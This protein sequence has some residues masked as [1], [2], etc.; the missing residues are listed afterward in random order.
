MVRAEG[1]HKLLKIWHF[2]EAP[3]IYVRNYYSWVSVQ[4]AAVTQ[5][6]WRPAPEDEVEGSIPVFD[7]TAY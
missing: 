3:N 2:A 4:L 1:D 5:L 6:L 7:G